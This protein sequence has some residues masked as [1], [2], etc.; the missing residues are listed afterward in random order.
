V[1]L[2][3]LTARVRKRRFWMLSALRAH[4]KALYKT[5]LLWETLRALRTLKRPGRART[6][7]RA[8]GDVGEARAAAGHRP[9][10]L[11]LRRGPAL[12]A[13]FAAGPGAAPSAGHADAAATRTQRARKRAE[14][15][16]EE[17]RRGRGSVGA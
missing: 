6:V 16:E 14:S 17:A 1:A 10:R 13:V 4:T 7:E 15:E 5:G 3:A 2:T 11:Q 8:V 12:V 9:V